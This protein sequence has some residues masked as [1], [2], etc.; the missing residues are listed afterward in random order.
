ME[1][2]LA[3]SAFNLNEQEVLSLPFEQV[4]GPS[5]AFYSYRDVKNLAIRK[6]LANACKLDIDLPGQIVSR[7]GMVRTFIKLHDDPKRRKRQ[8][9]M[10]NPRFSD[11]SI[12]GMIRRKEEDQ[13]LKGNV[14]VSST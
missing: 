13:Q 10:D 6:F 7:D 12:E 1:H 8:D 14:A 4:S 2:L 3:K 9:W 5:K 11:R